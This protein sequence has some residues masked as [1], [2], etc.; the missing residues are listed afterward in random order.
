MKLSKIPLIVG[1]TG[2]TMK[3]KRFFASIGL[4]LVLAFG[5]ANFASAFDD[6]PPG[7]R[8]RDTAKGRLGHGTKEIIT[9]A[10]TYTIGTPGEM[11]FGVGKCT[12]LPSGFTALT[13]HDDPYSP[14]RKSV[15]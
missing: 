8:F 7:A 10:P 3:K 14:D 15:V 11:G 6:T 1:K 2:E 5:C 12:T 4:C 9:I 13:G